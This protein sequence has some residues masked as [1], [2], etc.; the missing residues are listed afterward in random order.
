MGVD[1]GEHNLWWQR[2][3]GLIRDTVLVDDDVAIRLEY[4]ETGR[5]S[6][7]VTVI[8]FGQ[9]RETVAVSMDSTVVSRPA[10]A[11]RS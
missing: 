10:I 4:R 6:T 5:R 2:R 7:M 11:S 1:V 9:L 8:V 3:L